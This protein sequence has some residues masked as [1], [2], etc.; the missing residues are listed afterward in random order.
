VLELL[1][2]VLEY[3]AKA[4][5]ALMDE[6]CL[7]A[8]RQALQA[9]RICR[10]ASASVLA[11]CL[12]NLLVEARETASAPPEKDLEP[13]LRVVRFAASELCSPCRQAL[14]VMLKEDS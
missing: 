5:V 7:A 9:R 8:I 11:D 13:L 3:L 1:D 4:D 6:D 2:A 10:R 12:R 14:G